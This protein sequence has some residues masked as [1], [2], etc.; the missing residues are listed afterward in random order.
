MGVVVSHTI[1]DHTIVNMVERYPRIGP[2]VHDAVLYRDVL[3]GEII[4][5]GVDSIRGIPDRHSGYQGVISINVDARVT[6]P[7]NGHYPTT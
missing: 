1:N 4:G 2:I 6:I 3:D 5:V 7:F